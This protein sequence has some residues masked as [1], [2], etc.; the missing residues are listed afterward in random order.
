VWWRQWCDYVNFSSKSNSALDV[1]RG[2]LFTGRRTS[3]EV[4]E[5]TF[6]EKPGKICNQKLL[7]KNLRLLSNLV[8]HYDY[9]V[10]D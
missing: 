10:V 1:S 9:V 7:D 3:Q 5:V 2:S 6:Y 4:E 8:E